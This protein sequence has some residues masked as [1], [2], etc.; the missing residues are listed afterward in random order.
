MSGLLHW[1]NGCLQT[2]KGPVMAVHE[3]DAG[4]GTGLV[5]LLLASVVLPDFLELLAGEA[6]GR[7]AGR[8][9][10]ASVFL[11]LPRRAGLAVHAGG[12]V[13]WS[14]EEPG[15][16]A[17]MQLPEGQPAVLI[18]DAGNETRWTGHGTDFKRQGFGSAVLAS[19]PLGSDGTGVLACYAADRF[20]LGAD[21]ARRLDL[22]AAQAGPVVRLALRLDAQR[23]RASNLHA[24][25]ESRT[26]VDLAAGIIMGQNGCSQ[27]AAI[28]IL[29]SV[30]NTRNV[31]VRDV[32]AG[33]VAGVTDRFSTHFDE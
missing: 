4:A 20:A 13:S 27:Q 18:A 24:A 26:V 15:Q 6:A 12:A 30:S 1:G 8:G 19:L 31:K 22:F 25:L 23:Q 14:A 7:L 16:A 28:D 3:G 33:V 17:R 9:L 2:R 21:S 29:R 32:A 10:G 5:N 11:V